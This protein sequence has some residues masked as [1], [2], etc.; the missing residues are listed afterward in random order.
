MLKF[1]GFQCSMLQQRHTTVGFSQQTW[2]LIG[3]P[4][5]KISA[6]RSQRCP[7][8]RWTD[9]ID[10][11]IEMCM[12]K[13]LGFQGSMKQQ[14]YITVGFSQQTWQ[15]IGAP[16]LKISALRSQRC[17]SLRWDRSD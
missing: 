8:L 11:T 16:L 9:L 1:L 2:Q 6:F 3:A 15:L 17:P 4:L 14:H 7:T 12:L 10:K 5:L 13:F